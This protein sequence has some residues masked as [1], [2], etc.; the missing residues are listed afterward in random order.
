MGVYQRKNNKIANQCIF[1]TTEKYSRDLRAHKI[2]G[3]TTVKTAIAAAN[4]L[5]CTNPK[6]QVYSATQKRSM[7]VAT[8]SKLPG[9]KIIGMFCMLMHSYIF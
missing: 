8:D 3:I 6:K 2:R 1:L 4:I 9:K 5:A 7:A